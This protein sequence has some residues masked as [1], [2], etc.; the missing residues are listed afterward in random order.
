LPDSL[1]S[2]RLWLAFAIAAT[3]FTVTRFWIGGGLLGP[4]AGH[5]VDRRSPRVVVAVG[6]AFTALGLA[7]GA[8]APTLPVFIAAVAALVVFVQTSRP[9]RPLPA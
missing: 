3:A 2:S 8:L 1:A 4:L 5:L 7:V 9:P 6:V